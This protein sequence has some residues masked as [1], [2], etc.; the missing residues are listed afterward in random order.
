M[1]MISCDFRAEARAA[2]QMAATETSEIDRSDWLFLALAWQALA[3]R[4]DS[5]GESLKQ[6]TPAPVDA[7]TSSASE[8]STV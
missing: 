2:E 8:S 5:L 3:R 1:S 7:E 4:H 6:D